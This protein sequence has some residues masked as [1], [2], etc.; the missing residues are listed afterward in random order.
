VWA[1]SYDRPVRDLLSLQAAVATLIAK[2]VNV[3]V[4]PRL[5]QR[6][7]VRIGLLEP[8]LP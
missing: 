3:A 8:P 2:D 6:L 7:A 1:R 5:E 4:T